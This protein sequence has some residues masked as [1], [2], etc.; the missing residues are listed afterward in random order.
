M[1][2]T[3]VSKW[4]LNLLSYVFVKN[5][6]IFYSIPNQRHLVV[7]FSMLSPTWVQKMGHYLMFLKK[8]GTP[9]ESMSFWNVK[10][11]MHSFLVYIWTRHSKFINTSMYSHKDLV[12]TLWWSM[13]HPK[14]HHN[15]Y[16]SYPF[17]NK[18]NLML[19]LECCGN[20]MVSIKT[21]EKWINF[22]SS[23]SVNNIINKR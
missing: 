20:L 10:V 23:Y 11:I 6:F 17:N 7:Y 18:G 8:F 16:K 4:N 22:M 1:E 13:F 14:T 21:V 5:Y 3:M 9:N 12:I 19:I 15:P 2:I